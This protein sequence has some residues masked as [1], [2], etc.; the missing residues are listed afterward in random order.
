MPQEKTHSNV[1]KRVLENPNGYVSFMLVALGLSAILL[2][3]ILIK[4][5]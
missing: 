4:L 5:F 3:Y 1:K 2:I